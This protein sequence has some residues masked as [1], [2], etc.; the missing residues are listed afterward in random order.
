MSQVFFAKNALNLVKYGRHSPTYDLHPHIGGRHS[1]LYFTIQVTE[2]YSNSNVLLFR[3]RCSVEDPSCWPIPLRTKNNLG[4]NKFTGGL[5][6]SF[7]EWGRSYLQSQFRQT[8]LFTI[9]ILRG[10][11]CPLPIPRFQCSSQ[12][13]E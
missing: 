5:R 10:H 12:R 9:W 11:Q 2:K 6:K 4:P 7:G 1:V 3:R 13:Q 8:M